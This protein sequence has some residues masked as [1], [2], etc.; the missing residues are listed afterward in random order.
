MIILSTN[1]KHEPA[2]MEAIANN[3]SNLISEY[4]E[5]LSRIQKLIDEINSSPSWKNA[6]MKQAFNSTSN[7]YMR[8]HNNNLLNFSFNTAKLKEKAR[9]AAEFDQKYTTV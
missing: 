4:D 3:L 8:I 6:D 7:G 5:I 1:Y 2:Q 9:V